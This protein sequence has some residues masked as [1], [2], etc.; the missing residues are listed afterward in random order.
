MSEEMTTRPDS[1]HHWLDLV[2]APVFV[3]DTVTGQ[4][5]RSN[6]AFRRILPADCATAPAPIAAMLGEGAT[7]ALL[8]YLQTMPVDGSRNTLSLICP[9][10]HGPMMLILHLAEV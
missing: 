7:A 8:A 1:D 10:V 2:H 6:A 4:V 3:L 9:T 5:P